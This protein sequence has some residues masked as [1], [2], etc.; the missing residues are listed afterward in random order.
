[1]GV[2]DYIGRALRK[3]QTTP[4]MRQGIE[5]AAGK[6]GY[7]LEPEIKGNT[8]TLKVSST[9][10]YSGG[11]LA[12]NNKIYVIPRSATDIP[13]IKTGLPKVAYPWMVAP[14]FNHY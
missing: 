2:S 14:S 8:T 6:C 3:Y 10:S 4:Q 5:G 13:I 12:P 11:V 1:M 7:T 9:N